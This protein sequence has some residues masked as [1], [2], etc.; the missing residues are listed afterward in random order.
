MAAWQLQTRQFLLP[1]SGHQ[2]SECEDAVGINALKNRF[3]VA[4]G[5]TEAFDARSWASLLA[6]GWVE[7]TEAALTPREF[8]AWIEEQGQSLHDSWSGLRL[9]WYAEEKA[10]AGSF[11][12]FVGLQLELEAGGRPRWKAV[13]LGDSCLIHRRNKSLLDA[14]PVN[15]YEGFH[16]A[17]LLVP[18]RASMQE[19][20]LQQLVVGEGTIEAGDVLLL[21]SD[22]A[23][24]WYLMLWESDEKVLALFDNLIREDKEAE[25][26]R[27]FESE[28]VAGRIKDDDI[29]IVR[30]EVLGP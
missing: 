16:A 1:K 13:A 30:V 3:A 9:S 23:A 27:L 14:L 15:H 28:R 10:R 25:L 22:A 12:A 6:H 11:A 5:A 8:R 24:A 7:M 17:P 18:S 19:S 20:V 2:L 29:A 26:A 4:D 21:L